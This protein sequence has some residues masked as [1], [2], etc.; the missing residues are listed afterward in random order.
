M[1]LEETHLLSPAP[2]GRCRL[3]ALTPFRGF[4]RGRQR[5]V[6]LSQV[7]R[8]L[9]QMQPGESGSE[10]YDKFSL[11]TGSGFVEDSLKVRSCRLITDAQFGRGGPKCFACDQLKCQSGLGRGQPKVTPQQI[12]GLAH[13]TARDVQDDT[14]A[15]AASWSLWPCPGTCSSEPNNCSSLPITR[16]DR[17]CQ[18]AHSLE[19]SADAITAAVTPAGWTPTVLRDGGW[20]LVGTRYAVATARRPAHR[21]PLAGLSRLR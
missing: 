4:V 12:N 17:Y 15:S 9:H 11:S 3:V 10:D 18:N 21:A 7:S 8:G 20:R 5:F 16:K 14:S 6:R 2:S 19:P 1:L 13:V